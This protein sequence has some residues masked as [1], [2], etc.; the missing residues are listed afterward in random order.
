MGLFIATHGEYIYDHLRT[1]CADTGDLRGC[2]RRTPPQ[3]MSGERAAQILRHLP[4]AAADLDAG[5][6]VDRDYVNKGFTVVRVSDAGAYP[7]GILYLHDGAWK[8]FRATENFVRS[9]SVFYIK[10]CPVRADFPELF[11]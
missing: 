11:A 6:R 8:W 5:R 4:R 1:Y 10:N 3:G 9:L 2:V 7:F